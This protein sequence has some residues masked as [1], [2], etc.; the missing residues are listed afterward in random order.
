MA[1][2]NDQIHM[3]LAQYPGD[4]STADRSEYRFPEIRYMTHG[5]QKTSN[6]LI[7]QGCFGTPEQA[8]LAE[9]TKMWSPMPLLPMMFDEDPDQPCYMRFVTVTTVKVASTKAATLIV[10]G[11]NLGRSNRTSVFHQ[12]L[13]EA[14]GKYKDI[15]LGS[16]MMSPD[17]PHFADRKDNYVTAQIAVISQRVP[18]MLASPEDPSGWFAKVVGSGR[19]V[20]VQPKLNGLRVMATRRAS[21]ADVAA[22]THS[23][24]L[25]IYSRTM[26]DIT[27]NNFFEE[28]GTLTALYPDLIFDG[29]MYKHGESL[30]KISGTARNLGKGVAVQ[31]N[32]EYVIYDVYV[33]ESP[34]MPYGERYL[35]YHRIRE[36]VAARQFKYVHFMFATLMDSFDAVTAYYDTAIRDGYEGVMLKNAEAWYEPSFNGYHATAMCK[37][38]KSFAAEFACAGWSEGVGKATGKVTTWTAKITRQSHTGREDVDEMLQ[39]ALGKTFKCNIKAPDETR[40]AWFRELS[41]D[42][43]AFARQYSGVLMTVEF[44]ELSDAGLP[45][46]P[47]WIS[48]RTDIEVLPDDDEVVVLDGPDM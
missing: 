37:Y 17:S 47:Y 31:I 15:V 27:P 2:T 41:D 10:R 29:E 33:A 36:E 45:I 11:K 5:G 8:L 20:M 7:I 34:K 14:Y 40:I 13:I 42:A 16:R 18:P 6:V 4:F 26:K 44:F 28:V 30:Q 3:T 24:P 25:V 38:K 19:H 39:K 9:E 1:S 35:L 48:F 21:G 12:A 32:V 46:Q 22:G 43:G 23:R